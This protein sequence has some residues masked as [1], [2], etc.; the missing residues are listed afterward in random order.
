MSEIERK[1]IYGIGDKVRI[2]SYGQAL[3]INKKEYPEKE[4]FFA[5]LKHKAWFG[6]DRELQVNPDAK[7]SNIFAETNEY[8]MVDLCPQ[9]VGK[10]DIVEEVS[11]TQGIPSYS[12]KELGAWYYEDQMEMISKNPNNG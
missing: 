4:A 7:P 8:W 1:P 11:M 10:E 2:V 6:E 12:L 5:S 3:L 9:I